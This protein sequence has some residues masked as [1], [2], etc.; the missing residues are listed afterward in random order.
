MA[1]ELLE[2]SIFPLPNVVFF[3]GTLLPLHIFEPRYRKMVQDALQGDR[4]IGMVLQGSEWETR[5]S[6]I[7]EVHSV[8][9]LGRINEAHELDDGRYDI[10]LRG[11]SR[12]RIVEFLSEA[13][14]RLARVE[15]LV[16]LYEEQPED[17]ELVDQLISRFKDYLGPDRLG[18][19]EGKL[20]TKVD[21]T[22]LT[23]SVCSAVQ[24]PM[25]E[26]QALL[27]VDEVRIRAATVLLILDQLL[28][29]KRFIRGYT[30]LR[31]EDPG[32]N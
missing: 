9:G 28:S 32:K 15:L 25:R 11:V 27:E 12:F 4:R 3:P 23:N 24:I 1:P 29:R 17:Q 21:F 19:K 30:H 16:D 7:P 26:K 5:D 31:P 20:L 14:Y 10:L 22:T 8:G 13:P 2:L 6:G 18:S